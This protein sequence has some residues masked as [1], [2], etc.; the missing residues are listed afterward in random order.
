MV[1][2]VDLDD[3]IAQSEHDSMPRAHPLLDIHAACLRLVAQ[4]IVWK[5][6]VIHVH[7]SMLVRGTLLRCARLQIALKVL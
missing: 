2:E 4:F 1:L 7:F 5:M 3:L 6:A